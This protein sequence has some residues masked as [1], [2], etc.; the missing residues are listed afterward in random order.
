VGRPVDADREVRA[1]PGDLE[2]VNYD[3]AR[4][5][6]ETFPR[7]PN[8]VWVVLAGLPLTALHWQIIVCLMVLQ[9]GKGRH[10]AADDNGGG[11]D[12]H[13]AAGDGF[14]CEAV[15]VNSGLIAAITH[16]SVVAVRREL[17]RLAA[18]GIVVIH[19][20]GYKGRPQ[21]LSLNLDPGSW[22]PDALRE[23]FVTAKQN[24]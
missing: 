6:P 19:A 21:V 22:H 23:A 13:E 10:R 9:L 18:A 24:R 4:Y 20:Q 14:A 5:H 12:E 1:A 8:G 2:Y 17:R 3:P 7:V 15:A 16:R 11:Y